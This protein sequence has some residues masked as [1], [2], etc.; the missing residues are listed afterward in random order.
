MYA[1]GTYGLLGYIFCDLLEHEHITSCVFFVFNVMWQNVSLIQGHVLPR[2]NSLRYRGSKQDG[3]KDIKV[4][5]SYSPL[6]EALKHRWSGVP[7]RQTKNLNPAAVFIIL[8]KAQQHSVLGLALTVE[9]HYGSFRVV[10]RDISRMTR[11]MRMN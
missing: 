1:G 11:Y 3:G 7:R 4:K 2:V 9:Q 5:V 8:G 10:G 6:R